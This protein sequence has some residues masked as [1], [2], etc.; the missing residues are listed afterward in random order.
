[1]SM[2]AKV[3]AAHDSVS[4]VG[5]GVVGSGYALRCRCGTE[6]RVGLGE[7]GL[8]AESRA[9]T[10][11][12]TEVLRDLPAQLWQEGADTALD[13]AIRNDDG[14]TLRLEVPNPYAGE[15]R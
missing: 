4:Y 15:G 8:E 2:V 7:D 10:E 6:L 9:L 12:L 13:H 3:I 11:H 1:M 5:L 14:V